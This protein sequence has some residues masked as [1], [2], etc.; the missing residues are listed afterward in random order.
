MPQHHFFNPLMFIPEITYTLIV[1]IICL[2]IYLKTKEAYNLTKHKGIMYF[3]DAFLLFGIAYLIRFL[4]EIIQFSTMTFFDAFIPRR[5]IFPIVLLIMG[6]LSS[7]GILYLVFSTIWKKINNK[8]MIII[9]HIIAL[10]LS[11]IVFLTQSHT[12][13]LYLQIILLL[14]A[15]VTSMFSHQKKKKWF[16]QAKVLYLLIF[17]FWIMNMWIISPRWMFAPEIKSTLQIISLTVF[18]IIYYKVVKWL[19]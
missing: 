10:T 4:F 1:F 12:L 3:R 7:I 16:S 18:I 8:V 6:Y 19:K 14:I 11:I 13:M 17:I 2:L 15:V 5:F 9:G